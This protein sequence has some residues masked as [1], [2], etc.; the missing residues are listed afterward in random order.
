M[1]TASDFD[2]DFRVGKLCLLHLGR[3]IRQAGLPADCDDNARPLLQ[4]QRWLRR[5]PHADIKVLCRE[6]APVKSHYASQ[7]PSCRRG[8]SAG[9]AAIVAPSNSAAAGGG[10]AHGPSFDKEL[11]QFSVNGEIVR[12]FFRDAKIQIPILL[13]FENADWSPSIENPLDCSPR[14]HAERQLNN[15]IRQ[16]NLHQDPMLIHFW[17]EKGTQRIRWKVI[18]EASDQRALPRTPAALSCATID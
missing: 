18:D 14:R 5:V 4:F 3:A 9:C 6:L 1:P 15:G 13:A 11:R 7:L 16:L 10:H 8:Q 17:V 12:T 2:C